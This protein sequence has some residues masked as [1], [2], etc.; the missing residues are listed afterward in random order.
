MNTASQ[1]SSLL[2]SLSFLAVISC[3]LSAAYIL[4]GNVIA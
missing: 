1:D 4:L 2:E 3:L